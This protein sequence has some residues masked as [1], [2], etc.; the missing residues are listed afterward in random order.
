MLTL[1]SAFTSP[2]KSLPGLR[3]HSSRREAAQH[4]ADGGMLYEDIQKLGLSTSPAF[5]LY[6]TSFAQTLS[7]FNRLVALCSV[8]LVRPAKPSP[9]IASEY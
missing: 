4:T 2:A 5:L 9:P 6:L 7:Y 8:F 3:G 1:Q